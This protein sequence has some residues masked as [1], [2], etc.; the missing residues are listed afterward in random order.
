MDAKDL[1]KLNRYQLLELL[2]IQT[3]RADQ[4]Q[5]ELDAL[6]TQLEEQNIRL[7]KLG[8]IAEASLHVAGVFEAA[9]K[10]ADLYLDAAKL[11]AQT[12]EDEAK[13]T[14]QSILRQAE[15]EREFTLLSANLSDS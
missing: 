2:V 4:L 8:S 5:E 14:A 9:Q 13:K 10:A 12:I 3:R 1:K 7:S 15:I 6:R 11:Q